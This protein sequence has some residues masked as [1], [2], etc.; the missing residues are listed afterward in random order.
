MTRVDY[1]FVGQGKQHLP[2]TV[3]ELPVIAA[4]KV[5]P[6]NAT[7][8]QNIAVEDHALRGFMKTDVA[9]CVARC[10][11]DMKT[12]VTNLQAVPI[13]QVHIGYR[14]RIG[15]KAKEGRAT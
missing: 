4:R 9:W 2:D 11:E 8:E 15:A 7:T 1:R 12:K 3:Q 13:A 6:T 5:G 14:A 10:V